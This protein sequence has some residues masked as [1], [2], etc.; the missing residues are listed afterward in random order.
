MVDLHRHRLNW[1]CVSLVLVHRTKYTTHPPFGFTEKFQSLLVK[2]SY[3][4]SKLY[5]W[6]LYKIGTRFIA[7]K[8]PINHPA[9]T[10]NR[11]NRQIDQSDLY[12]ESNWARMEFKKPI[13]PPKKTKSVSWRWVEAADKWVLMEDADLNPKGEN[14]KILLLP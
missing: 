1:T 14:V 11:S 2:Q 10:Y 8:W 3:D 7:G 5:G 4:I 6:R 9:V 13:S 12:A